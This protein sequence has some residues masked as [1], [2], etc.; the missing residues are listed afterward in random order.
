MM[1]EAPEFRALAKYQA[2]QRRIVGNGNADDNGDDQA[3]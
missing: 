1:R 2:S 3:S